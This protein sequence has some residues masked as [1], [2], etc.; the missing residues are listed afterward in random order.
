MVRV[1]GS[2]TDPELG[3]HVCLPFLGDRERRDTT[4]LFA[5]NGLRRRTKVLI[6]THT[7]SPDRTRAWL[8]PLV[9]GFDEAES[10]GRI[11]IVGSAATHLTGGRLDPGRA[12]DG[13]ASARER[14]RAQ[15]HRGLYALVD[16]SWGVHDPP[17]Q[18]AFESAVNALF[19]QGG[20]AAVCQYDRAL[21]P[22]EALD[23]V[24]AAHPISPEQA[25][26]RHITLS[27]PPGVRLW[28]DVDL[29]NRQAF[30]SIL[31]P[32]RE[33]PED[34][35]IDATG[36][37]FIDAGSAQLLVAT[38]LA[39]GP[40]RTVVAC[41]SPLARL[42]HLLKAGDALGVRLTGDV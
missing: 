27:S 22:R 25:L 28:G 21:F 30:A 7:D 31:A 5:L 10:A 16:A 9:P 38:A 17:G 33:E 3:D 29:T 12:L 2:A 37:D 1:T 6:I 15:G 20:L 32:L 14:A 19:G 39:R 26:L 4:R 36:L 41:G 34:V 11:E 24:T 18:A 8:T 42:L 40:G 13:L 35:V 23:R